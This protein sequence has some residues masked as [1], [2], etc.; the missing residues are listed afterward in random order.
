MALLVIT[1]MLWITSLMASWLL[2]KCQGQNKWLGRPKVA[3]HEIKTYWRFSS[4]LDT[5]CFL[6]QMDSN[7]NH[8]NRHGPKAL[9]GLVNVFWQGNLISL[10]SFWQTH[11]LLDATSLISFYA[12]FCGSDKC[13][14]MGSRANLNSR[15]VEPVRLAY[16]PKTGMEF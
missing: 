6:C 15:S 4:V 3:K 11:L 14:E 7:E 8:I 13:E 2:A 10:I 1:P 5:R 16:M 9:V 12:I